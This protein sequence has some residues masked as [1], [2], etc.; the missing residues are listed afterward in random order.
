MIDNAKIIVKTGGGSSDIKE[1]NIT[2]II[3]STSTETIEREVT[4]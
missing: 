2:E 3:V 4:E 1:F